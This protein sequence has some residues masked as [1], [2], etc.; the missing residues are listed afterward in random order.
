[1][2]DDSAHLIELQINPQGTF[3]IYN[4]VKQKEANPYNFTRWMTI[5]N[6][7]QNGPLKKTKKHPL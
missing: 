5:I 6:I 1:M 4:D 3:L 7:K 2:D